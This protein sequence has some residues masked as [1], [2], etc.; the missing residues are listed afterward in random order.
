MARSSREDTEATRARVLEAA[1]GLF[2]ERGYADVGLEQVAAAAGVTRGAVYHHYG[3]KRGLFAAVH[4]RAQEVVGAAVE[5]ATQGL[6]DPWEMLEVGCQAFLAA[7]VAP[8]VRRVLLVDAPVVLGWDAWREQDEAHS[9]R[10]LG[11]VLDE[12]SDAGVIADLPTGA[13]T[14]VLSGAM[15]EAALRAAS[16]AD[17]TLGVDEGWRVLQPMVRALRR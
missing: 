10:M 5:D 3:S 1:R 17:P 9:A 13:V 12:L 6:S 16:L 4:R 14:A 7:A 11:E 8:E 15:N 2:A